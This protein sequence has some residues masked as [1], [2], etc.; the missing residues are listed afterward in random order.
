MK[1]LRIK[2][3]LIHGFIKKILEIQILMKYQIPNT[4]HFHRELKGEHIKKQNGL[5][6]QQYIL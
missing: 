1:F 4:T 5:L 3:L 6:I 2:Y